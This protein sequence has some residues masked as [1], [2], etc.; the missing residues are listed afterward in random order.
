M[1]YCYLYDEEGRFTGEMERVVAEVNEE[2][3]EEVFNLPPQCTMKV[4]PD[5]G[6]FPRFMG[7]KWVTREE[8]V[9]D[10]QGRPISN[11]EGMIT[12]AD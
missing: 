5:G 6:F 12:N 1:P 4:P 9:L 2:T 3:G 8:Y 10:E 7:T 11:Q